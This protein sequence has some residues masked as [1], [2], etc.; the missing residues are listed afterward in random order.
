M[1]H[2]SVALSALSALLV[3][4]AVLAQAPF[5]EIHAHIATAKAADQGAADWD[6]TLKRPPTAAGG[7]PKKDTKARRLSAPRQPG[8]NH[9]FIAGAEG[10]QRYFTVMTECAMASKLRAGAK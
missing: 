2:T 3:G 1:K 4:T 10:V 8:E 7:V 6:A 5:S 9:P